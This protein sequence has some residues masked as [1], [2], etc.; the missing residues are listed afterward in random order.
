MQE[1]EAKDKKDRRQEAGGNE[2]RRQCAVGSR[3]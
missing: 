2:D 3:Q 1:T